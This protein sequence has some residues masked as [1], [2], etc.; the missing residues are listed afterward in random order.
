MTIFRERVFKSPI[1]EHIIDAI[2]TQ[3]EIEREEHSINRSA[4]RSCVDVFLQLHTGEGAET[5]YKR[6]L[7][8]EILAAS[9]KYYTD[10]GEK[11]ITTCD[12]PEFL[13]RVRSTSV[14]GVPY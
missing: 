9:R 11:L 6:D 3:I 14:I 5:V 4:V 2:L 8:P 1:K 12:A 13:R 7:E 10:E